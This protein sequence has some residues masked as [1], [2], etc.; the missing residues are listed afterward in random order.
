MQFIKIITI[1]LLIF[2]VLL[3]LL[4]AMGQLVAW[5]RPSY[6]V[7]YLQPD[8]AVGWK[9]VPN[10]SW[11]WT[12]HYWYAVDFSVPIKTNPLGF[13]DIA[14]EFSKPNGV[15]R[16]VL[17]GDSLI[18]AVQVPLEKTAGYLL[19]QKLKVSLQN[20]LNQ[21][22]KWEVLNFGISNYGVGQYLLTYEEY[23]KKY[24]PDYVAIFVA[25]F[26]MARTVSKYEGGAFPDTKNEQFWVRP[27]FKIEN[28]RLVRLPAEDFDKFVTLQEEQIKNGFDRQRM[29][30]KIQLITLYQGKILLQQIKNWGRKFYRKY[31]KITPTQN[32]PLIDSEVLKVNLKVIEVLGEQVKNSG[33]H[34]IVIDA[35]QYFGDQESVSNALKELSTENGF[36]YIPLYDFLLKANA[37]GISTTWAHDGHF[38][39]AGNVIL[40]NA[41]ADWIAQNSLTTKLQ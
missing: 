20:T 15:K 21:S 35:S 25:Y 36:G 11:R 5:L 27:V 39:E 7:L 30:K 34:L 10:L 13:R 19:E 23:A 1:N 33:A 22:E 24:S 4:E 32:H 26:H 14:R 8:R 12:G 2:F 18:E 17:L 29:R 38:N 41:L 6:E 40:A 28:D 3:L 16:V 9:Q 31:I 37:N